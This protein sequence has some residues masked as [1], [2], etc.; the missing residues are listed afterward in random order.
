MINKYTVSQKNCAKLF[1]QNFVN[2]LPILIIFGRKM[3]KKLKLCEVIHFSTLPNSRA[4]GL[5]R[6]PQYS[7]KCGP[8]RGAESSFGEL[9]CDGLSQMLWRNQDEGVS[10]EQSGD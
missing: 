5:E 8:V 10:V 6:M 7:F 2:F 4:N 9:C 3:A 1:C